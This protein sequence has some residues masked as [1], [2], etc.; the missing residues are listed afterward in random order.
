MHSIELIVSC[1]FFIYN[2]YR[3]LNMKTA[4]SM[5]LSTD[6]NDINIKNAMKDD[7]IHKK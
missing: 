1:M 6:L 2:A 5:K 7:I 4:H 3:D